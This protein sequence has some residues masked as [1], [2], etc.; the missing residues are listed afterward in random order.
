MISFLNSPLPAAQMSH[1]RSRARYLMSCPCDFQFGQ[2]LPWRNLSGRASRQILCGLEHQRYQFAALR[3]DLGTAGQA[4]CG[5]GVNVMQFNY[6]FSFAGNRITA[7]N[8]RSDPWANFR[9]LLTTAAAIALCAS[10][11]MP[12]QA[13]SSRSD[14]GR[15]CNN[16]FLRL[17]EAAVTEPE[18][19]YRAARHS[20]RCRTADLAAG[21]ERHGAAESRL[22][23]WRSCLRRRRCEPPKQLRWCSR[24]SS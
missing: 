15:A 12:I 24:N 23:R 10:I 8:L 16:R 11:S 1:T 5:V 9:L 20:R 21:L 2:A 13:F 14:L 6:G 4:L 18:R 19:A 7:H 3:K 22:R 17:L